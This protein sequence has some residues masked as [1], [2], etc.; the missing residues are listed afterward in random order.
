MTEPRW[1][2]AGNRVT[3][4]TRAVGGV[5]TVEGDTLH[6]RPTALERKLDAEDWA[7][8]LAGITGFR[9][10]PVAV[11]DAFAGGLRPRL[12]LDAGRGTTHLFV[13]RDPKAVAKRLLELAVEPPDADEVPG[14][15]ARA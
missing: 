10:A 2:S 5:L 1:K 4:R 8:P 13:V 11:L 12:A 14:D 6:F 9:V 7:L 15:D 3:S